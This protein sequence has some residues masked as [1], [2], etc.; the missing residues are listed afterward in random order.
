MNDTRAVEPFIIALGDRDK[1][2]Q[3]IAAY[4]LGISEDT[5]A[6]EPLISALKGVYLFHWDEVPGL[7]EQ[8][9]RR[10]VNETLDIGWV[11]TAHIEKNENN[12]VLVIISGDKRIQISIRKEHG[13]AIL[14]FP[15]GGNRLLDYRHENGNLTLYLDR[16]E[17]FKV[18]ALDALS[19]IGDSR[20]IEPAIK[21]LKDRH[22]DVRCT[23]ADVLGAFND[24]RAVEPLIASLEEGR[25][26]CPNNVASALGVIKDPRATLPLIKAGMT[27]VVEKIGPPAVE[28]LISSLRDEDPKVRMLS[29]LVLGNIQDARAV[30][31]LEEASSDEDERVRVTAED[32]LKKVQ[33]KES[34]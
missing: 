14:E 15:N 26:S 31:A 25:S 17:S 1:D 9:I 2:V 20:A 8:R 16:G 6:V 10:T 23:A 21:A 11:E 27:K 30:D 28:P 3:R 7:G 19:S 12:E 33:S 4:A 22:Y 18:T 13:T 24:T 29:A 34:I 5:R 32:A